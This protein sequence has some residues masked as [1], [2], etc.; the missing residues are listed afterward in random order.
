M[1]TRKS[2]TRC[3]QCRLLRR[4]RGAGAAGTSLAA[5]LAQRLC[6]AGKASGF[7]VTSTE[8]DSPVDRP[9]FHFRPRLVSACLAGE[10]IPPPISFGGQYPNLDP[11]EPTLVSVVSEHNVAVDFLSETGRAPEF[12]FGNGGFQCVAAQFIFQDLLPVQPVL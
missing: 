10:I 4:P 2:T 3:D 9:R 6:S 5:L 7:A 8:F 12:A 11:P 1:A